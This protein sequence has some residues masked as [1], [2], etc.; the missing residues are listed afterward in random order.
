MKK[1]ELLYNQ[2]VNRRE[3][4]SEFKTKL[5][6]KELFENYTRTAIIGDKPREFDPNKIIKNLESSSFDFHP[7]EEAIIDVFGRPVIEI[8]NN[9]FDHNEPELDFWKAILESYKQEL[10]RLIPSI[11][12]IELE[13]HPN[14]DWAGT[15]WL[16]RDDFIITNRHV[17]K[18]FAKQAGGTFIFK[19]TFWGENYQCK[20]DFKEEHQ[21]NK[22]EEYRIDKIIHIEPDNGP[23]IAVLKIKWKGNDSKLPSLEL[24]PAVEKDQTI[25]VIGYP[26]RD[27]RTNIPEEQL[28]IFSNIFNKKRLSVGEIDFVDE[29]DR[30]FIHDCTTLGGNSGSPVIDIET[31]KVY[32]L[33]FAGREREGNFAVTSKTLSSVLDRTI[34]K[35]KV[36]I[37]T[38]LNS[39]PQEE[40][41]DLSELNNRT[42]YDDGFLNLKIPFPSLSKS[43]KKEVATLNNSKSFLLNYTHYSVVMSKK[44]Q[45]ALATAVNIHG[46]KWRNIVRGSD[47]WKKDPRI[48][49]SYQ[50][51][52]ELY[53]HNPLDRGHLVRRLDPAWG[54]SY[55]AAKK[56]VDETFFYTNCAPQHKSL[57]RDIWL[58]LEDYILRNVNK[59]D[60]KVSVFNGPVFSEHDMFYK[61]VQIPESFWKVVVSNN[62]NGI[63]ATAYILSQKK[64][65]T[66]LE[67]VFG[68]YRT[69]Q[70]P[71]SLV[72]KLS[73]LSFGPDITQN[74]PL[75]TNEESLSHLSAF[76]ELA[77]IQ[78]I[79]L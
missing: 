6:D 62:G 7:V 73:H 24:A 77:H 58:D 66:D 27:S 55:K 38:S 4:F 12:R 1:K 41:I 72:E 9:T 19:R 3:L 13:G 22:S 60:M 47:S 56:G 2:L 46:S 64:W 16:Y 25:A 5:K 69:Y 30:F 14:L 31:Q 17:A 18:E 37:S 48:D 8:R 43:L 74:D 32:G 33:H 68:P 54:D 63:H 40:K 50:I 59:R 28:R 65:L 34:N 51:G 67:F 76:H 36:Q 26:A 61:G 35:E 20:I 42:G 78:Q 45:L 49:E 15:G 71:V 53:E 11:G 29:E 79:V 44:K 10:G 21:G 39:P 75:Q 52:N 23:D 57:N 70:V